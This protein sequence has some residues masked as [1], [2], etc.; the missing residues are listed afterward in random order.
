MDW[1]S[2]QRPC[3]HS[4]LSPSA[5]GHVCLGTA[6]DSSV[7]PMK[8]GLSQNDM[9]AAQRQVEAV[10]FPSTPRLPALELRLAL[11]QEGADT[12]LVVLC[13][14]CDGLGGASDAQALLQVCIE[15]LVDQPFDE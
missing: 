6:P 1:L 3:S 7:V 10:V 14:P 12:L 2:K 5:A 8:S 15:R 13:L 4:V 9:N 11:L